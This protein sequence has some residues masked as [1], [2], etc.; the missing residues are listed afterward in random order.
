MEAIMRG[1]RGSIANP[2]PDTAFYGGNTACVELRTDSGALFFFDAGT[3]LREAGDHLP[4]SGECHI[5]ISH[6]HADHIMSLWF[7]KPVHFRQEFTMS[8]VIALILGLALGVS[9]AVF[10][11]A[12]DYPEKSV[13]IV[14][15]WRPGGGNDI[16]ARIVGEAMKNILGQAFVVSNIEGAAGLN[17]A[18]AVNRARPDGYFLLWEFPGNLTVGPLLTKANY[19]WK[20]FKLICAVGYSDMVMIAGANAPWK[21]ARDAVKDIKENPKKIRWSIALNAMSHLSFLNITRAVGEL[22]VTVVPTQGDK[23][24]VIS[25]IGNNSDISTVAYV[26]AEPYIKSGDLKILAMAS[27]ERSVFAPDVPTLKEQGIDAE[28]AYYYTAIAPKGTP[29][30]IAT[31]LEQAFEKAV[32]DPEVKKLFAAQCVNIKFMKIDDTMKYWQ[33]KAVLYESLAKANG[34]IR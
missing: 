13:Q 9:S 2:S 18:S 26:A 25:I 12:A 8:K 27:P 3:G 15:P 5:F 30:S 17:G 31:I 29:D 1:V 24:R 4:G 22:D 28:D 6:S 10:A 19:S 14:V 32:T 11:Q 16:S 21:D 34:L 20:D 33:E 23:G 7:F